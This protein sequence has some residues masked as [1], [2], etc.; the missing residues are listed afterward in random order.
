MVFFGHDSNLVV[1]GVVTVATVLALLDKFMAQ[2]CSRRASMAEYSSS[3]VVD[4]RAHAQVVV[5]VDSTERAMSLHAHRSV[6]A[7]IRTI[8]VIAWPFVMLC[9]LDTEDARRQVVLVPLLWNL[10]M[11]LVDIH[12]LHHSTPVKD[13]ALASVRLDPAMFCSLTF[14]LC[15]LVGARTDSRYSY[16][17][18]Y[19][20]LGCIMFI[21]P[22]TTLARE[23][24]EHVVI[25][26]VQRVLLYYCTGLILAGVTLTRYSQAYALP[27]S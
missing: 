8:G 2:Q 7:L 10:C 5:V 24:V 27:R 23:C 13:A 20:V 15:G 1:L 25:E 18:M 11:W 22:Q 12:I 3:Q 9:T 6:A 19:A 21:L 4:A 26:N 14:G 16:L 17:F